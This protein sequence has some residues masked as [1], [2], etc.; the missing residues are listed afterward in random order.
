MN[1]QPIFNE[2][3][4]IDYIEIERKENYIIL[5]ITE[6][7]WLEERYVAYSSKWDYGKYICH[8][9]LEKAKQFINEVNS[10]EPISP[11]TI[12]NSKVVDET[13]EIPSWLSEF[14]GLGYYDLEDIQQSDITIK[15]HTNSE[16]DVMSVWYFDFPVMVALKGVT[17]KSG[18]DLNILVTDSYWY[19]DIV[20]YLYNRYINKK[21]EETEITLPTESNKDISL[22]SGY[23]IEDLLEKE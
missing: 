13:T 3:K 11:E 16:I 21:L 15:L 22:M 6:P 20:R 7:D 8:P 17:E 2:L 18:T 1:F 10:K 9:T 12:Y 5:Q 14:I 23:F 19:Q 4:G